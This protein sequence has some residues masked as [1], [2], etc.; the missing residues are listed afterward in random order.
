MLKFKR[1]N[2]SLEFY[3]L[4]LNPLLA[5]S[6]HATMGVGVETADVNMYSSTWLGPTY[7]S[8]T[9][10]LEAGGDF[11]GDGFDDIVVFFGTEIRIYFGGNLPKSPDLSDRS[12]AR[13]LPLVSPGTY[14]GPPPNIKFD[15]LDGDG[16]DDL[17]VVFG[18]TQIA[19]VYYGQDQSSL[20]QNDPL[21]SADLTLVSTDSTN[22][23][24]RLAVGDAD[25]DAF[26]DLLIGEPDKRSEAGQ[27]SLLRGTPQRK[28]GTMNLNEDPDLIRF[29]G[30]PPYSHLGAGVGFGRQGPNGPFLHLS[31]PGWGPV[32]AREIGKVYI[33]NTRSSFDPVYIASQSANTQIIGY[34][35]YVGFVARKAGDIDGDGRDELLC[36]DGGTSNDKRAYAIVNGAHWTAGSP[37]IYTSSSYASD[38]SFVS[39]LET[40]DDPSG[41][42]DGDHRMDFMGYS[43]FYSHL[44]LGRDFPSFPL[45][46]SQEPSIVM[47]PFGGSLTTSF[48][49]INGDGR[50]DVVILEIP[51]VPT[52]SF[53]GALRVIYG[54]PGLNHPSVHVQERTPTSPRVTLSLSAEGN[55]TEVR[56]SE[57]IEDAYRDKWVPF[58]PTLRASMTPEP[59]PKTIRAT[60]RNASGRESETVEDTVTL[61]VDQAGLQTLSNILRLGSGQPVRF[62]CSVT[63]TAH[64]QASVYTPEG[65]RVVDLLDEQRGPGVWP[66][67][68]NGTNA[69]GRTVAPGVYI[70]ALTV[71]GRTDRLRIV[72]RG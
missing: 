57:D 36:L 66:V 37:V 25:G 41:D 11:D 19:R 52:Q 15:D 6:A 33:F 35:P 7:P 54:F 50:H 23:R 3:F 51:S 9:E 16:K 2:F 32:G 62:E 59:G 31:A 58:A 39:I 56:L 60:F 70:L 63:E 55:P 49:D 45:S 61:S 71:N 27:V 17:L 4:L 22:W 38:L 43:S 40:M 34:A 72:V 20:A 68:W 10:T 53:N 13:V 69:A 21:T 28:T 14:T 64:L 65:E 26:P 24:L 67:E 48:G 12:M 42:F 18:T 29:Y 8:R 46:V 47:T 5:L 1:F 44:Y 30:E